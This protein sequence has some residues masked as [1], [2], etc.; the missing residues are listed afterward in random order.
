MG[1]C[2]APTL[3]LSGLHLLSPTLFSPVILICP[4]LGYG[5]RFQGQ[6]LEALPIV[7]TLAL[8][9]AMLGCMARFL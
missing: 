3:F 6:A 7:S 9:L 1:F 4:S 8:N 2:P 5:S